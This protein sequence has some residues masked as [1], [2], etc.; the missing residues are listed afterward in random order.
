MPAQTTFPEA[1][2]RRR[3]LAICPRKSPV[4][5]QTPDRMDH[6]RP[7]NQAGALELPVRALVARTPEEILVIELEGRVIP[8]GIAGVPVDDPI[9]R[10]ELV[11]RMREP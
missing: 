6:L 9:G 3:T 1:L 11:I 2:S 5:H 10:G 4:L 8:A 7:G